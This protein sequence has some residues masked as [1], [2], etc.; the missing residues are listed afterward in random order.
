MQRAPLLVDPGRE[1]RGIS[2]PPET[3]AAGPAV[4]TK[5]HP[6]YSR[7][8]RMP[9]SPVVSQ[10][11]DE[12]AGE[13]TAPCAPD[14]RGER[15]RPP[16]SAPYLDPSFQNTA[17]PSQSLQYDEDTRSPVYFGHFILLF[18][19]NK[20]P[21]RGLTP[22]TLCLSFALPTTL[23]EN[24]GRRSLDSAV[25]QHLMTSSPLARKSLWKPAL[26]WRNDGDCL[27]DTKGVSDFSSMVIYPVVGWGCCL[28]PGFSVPLLLRCKR[29]SCS[30]RN[31]H[32]RPLRPLELGWGRYH[33]YVGGVCMTRM[34]LGGGVECDESAASP[35]III[36]TPSF[37]AA[38]HQAPDGSGC[39]REEVRRNSQVWRHVMRHTWCEWSLITAAVKRRGH[40]S[41]RDRSLSRAHLLVSSWVQEG[42]VEGFPCRQRHEPPDPQSRRNC[43][44]DAAVG[45]GCRT[46]SPVERRGPR[47]RRSRWKSHRPLHPGPQ[48]GA[49]AA[50]RLCPLPGP[51]LPE[52]CPAFT[53][54]A[55]RQGHQIPCLFWTL[56]PLWTLYFIISVK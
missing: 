51:L 24:A 47:G 40:F 21:L 27:P 22:R 1:R 19:L 36:I 33:S 53:N 41:S 34:L 14:L 4:Q 3:W 29:E 18:L 23:V 55:A 9:T 25:G 52:H 30:E 46:T 13:A 12:A 45:P 35:I 31:P 10:E 15:M 6:W 28:K 38:L 17:P 56:F 2:V 11:A 8:A 20:K 43:T 37:N 48:R 49:R 54:P 39:V 7:Q 50:A 32:P 26:G 42:N 5:L 16:D 44:R